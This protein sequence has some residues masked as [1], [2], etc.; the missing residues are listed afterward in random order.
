MIHK[1]PLPNKLTDFREAIRS[2][3]LRL[4]FS[5]AGFTSAEPLS[6]AWQ[7]RWERWRGEDKAGAMRYLMRERPRRTHPRDLLPEARA[8]LVVLAGYYDGD[9]PGAPDTPTDARAGKI[10]RYAWGRD[11]HLVIREGLGRLG[12][13]I[14]EHYAE[15]GIGE[16]P[17]FRPCVD[18]APLD[19]RALAVRAGLGFIG[20]NTLLLDPERGSWSLIGVLLTSLEL[21]PDA[22]LRDP[23]ASCGGCR[24]CLDAC[25]T[26]AFDDAYRLDPRRCTS[27]LTIEQKD[28][29]PSDLAAKMEG[30]ALGCD[31]CQEVCPFN[32]EP[33]TRLLPGLA[34]R[35]GTGPWL[36]GSMLDASPSG[37]AFQRQW[38][39]TPLSRPGLKGLRRNL[40]AATQSRKRVRDSVGSF[41]DHPSKGAKE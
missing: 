13:W 15:F 40:D 3:V 41:T 1:V 6:P 4:G 28:A 11:Y 12:D 26:R 33:L 23:A 9:H 35:E 32:R 10:A 18:S 31:I 39:H 7:R 19:E 20:K 36:T 14:T 16:K 8:V 27:Y 30:W 37:K 5:R 2:E 17:V 24:R 25:P 22:P 38:G 21:P 34:A 29:I